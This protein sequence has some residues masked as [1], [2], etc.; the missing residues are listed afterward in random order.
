MQGLG[1]TLNLI[2]F[3]ETPDPLEAC[4]PRR[5]RPSPS[6]SVSVLPLGLQ[7]STTA[8]A[9]RWARA[10]TPGTLA[11]VSGLGSA[12]E[13][14][15]L[16]DRSPPSWL[17]RPRYKEP[18]ALRTYSRSA[19]L[20]LCPLHASNLA[21]LCRR[22]CPRPRPSGRGPGGTLRPGGAGLDGAGRGAGRAG[23]GGAGGARPPAAPVPG[24]APPRPRSREVL[25]GGRYWALQ[26]RG[27]RLGRLGSR[28]AEEAGKIPELSG[29]SVDAQ[30]RLVLHVFSVLG[31]LRS[32]HLGIFMERDRL[33]IC[34]P[35]PL[36]GA[37]GMGLKVQASHH[38]WTFLESSPTLQPSGS[39]QDWPP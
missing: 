9:R 22:P 4:P 14:R 23:R 18:Q 34:S 38:G 24:R 20:H 21:C 6:D 27:L 39:H 31:A 29:N 26:R 16:E 13:R 11:S 17:N 30:T 15:A 25:G 37:W 2:H 35:P 3:D 7:A 10:R 33:L 19:P 36:P 5:P 28:G 32:H 8:Q 12:D 1:L